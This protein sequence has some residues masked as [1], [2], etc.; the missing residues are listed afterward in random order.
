MAP[1]CALR[2][3][4]CSDTTAAE[5]LCLPGTQHLSAR[6]S[7]MHFA[8]QDQ[9]RSRA[10]Q[11]KLEGQN[12]AMV[13]NAH[14]RSKGFGPCYRRAALKATGKVYLHFSIGLLCTTQDKLGSAAHKH[15]PG[16][17]IHQGLGSRNP[18][19][20]KRNSFLDSPEQIHEAP[21]PGNG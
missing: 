20:R 8:E 19:T 9:V 15:I 12:E 5:P 2:S 3:V 6:K 21:L 14:S 13:P 1:H 16:P 18:G 10:S 11:C 7:P 4:S 17:R